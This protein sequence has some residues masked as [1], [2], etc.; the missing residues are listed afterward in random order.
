MTLYY[1]QNTY[2]ECNYFKEN[3]TCLDLMDKYFPR[4]KLHNFNR[5]ISVYKT[6]ILT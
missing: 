5:D 3:K 2:N 6:C 1:K 4:L